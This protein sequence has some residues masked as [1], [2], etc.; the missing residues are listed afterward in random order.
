MI[1]TVHI[2]KQHTKTGK[3]GEHGPDTY[4][5]VTVAPDGVEV[6]Y[7]LNQN[8]LAKRGIKIYYFGE[9]YG[10]YSGPRSMLGRSIAAA[11]EFAAGK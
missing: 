7:Y 10:R 9:G 3:S 4:V 8:V 6:P 11:K 1:A 5:A 2:R